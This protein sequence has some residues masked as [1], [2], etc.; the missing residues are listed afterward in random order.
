MI[1][2]FLIAVLV[3][4]LYYRTKTS[5]TG[6]LPLPSTSRRGTTTATA[7]TWETAAFNERHE[8]FALYL[9]TPFR[10]RRRFNTAL[11]L[12]YDIGAVL[13]VLAI[14]VAF[15][16][17][18]T[19]LL[20][21]IFDCI[22]FLVLRPSSSDEGARL[23]KRITD[24]GTSTSSG[25]GLT[26]LIP[27]LTTPL[28]DAP[29]L[30]F[31]LLFA[32]AFHEFG[33]A[34]ASALPPHAS[35]LHRVG[36]SLR[37]AYV[38]LVQSENAKPWARIRVA[39]AG[40]WHNIVLGLGIWFVVISGLD[41][42]FRKVLYP[43]VE[44][45]GLV[46]FDVTGSSPL[47]SHL[48]RGAF[49][50]SLDDIKLDSLNPMRGDPTAMQAWKSH[51]VTWTD[52]TLLTQGW[53]IPQDTFQGAPSPSPKCSTQTGAVVFERFD[54][55]IEDK[56][57]HCLDPLPIFK[58]FIRCHHT[59][60]CAKAREKTGQEHVCV[61]PPQSEK[62]MRIGVREEDHTHLIVW[63]GPK[64]EVYDQVDVRDFA[65][66]WSFVPLSLL[67][68]IEAIFRYIVSLTWVLALV[69]MLPVKALD[70]GATLSALLTPLVQLPAPS[71]ASSDALEASD[72][73]EIGASRLPETLTQSLSRASRLQ[74]WWR[75]LDL[76]LTEGSKERVE[77][78]LS[79]ATTLMACMTLVMLS[80]Y[81]L[82]GLASSSTQS[83]IRPGYCRRSADN[84]E[85]PM[86]T[87]VLQARRRMG[88]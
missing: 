17:L 68:E 28:S 81:T 33:H 48:E 6:V 43:D 55:S 76:R 82:L 62:V 85:T 37:G 67:L 29:Q 59:G 71:L 56:S 42:M 75:R 51:L 23:S 13:G 34:V 45:G 41:G 21:A 79:V 18:Q 74:W 52:D 83:Y 58:G 66:R 73:L 53:C 64:R 12:F 32:Q 15:I 77:E 11:T 47:R 36:V 7:W 24:T 40:A 5:H 38:A 61:A 54:Y 80:F 4:F 26:L 70:G 63:R 16:Y 50:T 69:N 78:G 22:D 3:F 84:G 25:G 86:V 46:V 31:A 14:P 60:Q 65:P 49:V 8:A 44:G 20:R 39:A 35:A 30:V 57:T 19:T 87:Y 2:V 27:G 88:L 9:A 1:F 72:A 10:V